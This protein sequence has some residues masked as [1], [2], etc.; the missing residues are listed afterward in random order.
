[1]KRMK[2]VITHTAGEL[3]EA[4]GLTRAEGVEISV[5]S[6]LNTKIIDVVTKRGLTHAEVA[7]RVGTSRTR[8]TA[9]LT[10]NTQTVSTDLLLRVRGALG[11]TA[12]VTFVRGLGLQHPDGREEDLQ[13]LQV[14]QIGGVHHIPT[15]SR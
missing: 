4:L 13:V 6:A 9:I 5:R 2:P 1:M 3:A 14:T 10:R 15:A 12:K 11:M 7:T 8:I